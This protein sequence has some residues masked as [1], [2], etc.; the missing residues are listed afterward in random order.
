MKLES[1]D[2]SEEKRNKLLYSMVM[3]ITQG[4]EYF[5]PMTKLIIN[6]SYWFNFSAL[7][8]KLLSRW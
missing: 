8:K 2:S 4:S 1:N 7:T 5:N 6:W 3:H